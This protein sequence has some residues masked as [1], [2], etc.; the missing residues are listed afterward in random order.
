MVLEIIEDAA[1]AAVA[2]IGFAAISRPP[3]R[4]YKW[5]AL[6]A[7]VGHSSRYMFINLM[8]IH[9]VL[10]TFFA[11]II[12]GTLA[13]FLSPVARTPA[14]G[15]L[16]PSLLPMIPGIFAYKAFGAFA[17]C[18]LYP[19]EDVFSKNFYLFAYNAITCGAILLAMVIGATIPLMLFKKI[20]YSATRRTL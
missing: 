2:A 19:S 4:A 6:I 5:C 12:I 18:V 1:F 16:F 3:R 11:A 13:V 9:I 20:T 8:D 17:L 14:E 10:A 7:A 15:A